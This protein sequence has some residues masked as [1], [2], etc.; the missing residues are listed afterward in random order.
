M[1]RVIFLHHGLQRKE[2]R[3]FWD[4]RIGFKQLTWLWVRETCICCHLWFLHWLQIGGKSPFWFHK[5]GATFAKSEDG[6]CAVSPEIPEA[7]KL[8]NKSQHDL[9][10]NGSHIASPT[11]TVQQ[12]HADSHWS[13]TFQ[14]SQRY[15]GGILRLLLRLDGTIWFVATTRFARLF[16]GVGDG[17]MLLCILRIAFCICSPTEKRHLSLFCELTVSDVFAVYTCMPTP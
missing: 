8:K 13:K 2:N 7:L 11:V 16:V 15:L 17:N 4:K 10:I 3:M 14:T 6:F 1:A 12:L 5:T 9:R